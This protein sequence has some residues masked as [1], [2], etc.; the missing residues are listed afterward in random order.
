MKL[1]CVDISSG[2]ISATLFN[3]QLA[4]AQVVED[5]WI[6]ETD[7][8]GTATL[9]TER[10]GG[11]FKNVLRA[12]DLTANSTIDGVCIGS[13]LHSCVLLDDASRPLS[14][15]FTWL[16]RRGDEGIQHVRSLLGD[17]FHE[18]TG[19]R[20]HPM[21]PVFKLA[22]MRLSDPSLLGKA[23]RVVSLKSL[24]LH[25][26]TGTWVEDDGL[27]SASGLFN[28]ARRE[29][30]VE[31]LNILGLDRGQLPSIRSRN[32]IAGPVTSKAAS[33]FGLP[34]GA[35]VV[36]GSGDG[37]L[38][39][40]GSECEV[41]AKIGVTL[42]TS[43]VVRQ[44]LSRAVLD[45][46]AGTFCYRA[47]ESIFILGCAGSN[48]GNVLDWGRGILGTTNE[49]EVSENLP[50]FVPLLHGERSPDWDPHLTGSWHGLTARHTAAD[51]SKS[52]LEGVIF[53]LAH[54]IEIVQRTSRE[55]AT[56]LVL[57]GN[58]FLHAAA[59]PLLATV[60]GISTWVPT[61]PGL[62]SL[63]G[64]GICALRALREPEPPLT[65]KPVVPLTDK[66]I[67]ERYIEYRRLRSL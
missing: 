37:F 24:L 54:F 59:G 21:F 23:K 41:P 9:S 52:I 2:G 39:N 25:W 10:V 22:A 4:A 17:R 35:A 26:L 18:I 30:D 14:A 49:S 15:V 58:G 62:A 11:I 50:I 32:E 36:V 55:K 53:N 47:D 34:V 56:D 3:S 65:V 16:D 44:T 33:E 31:I 67:V 13:F 61:Q 63:R 1:L 46:D 5:R 64:A 66:R 43:A 12:L 60:T 28:I 40:I 19:C 8:R 38:A 29:W 6:L 27:A 48:G 57:S 42:G 7:D 51:L 45:S 20:Y